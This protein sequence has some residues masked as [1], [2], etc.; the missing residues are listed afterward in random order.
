MTFYIKKT[1]ERETET[2]HPTL[3]IVFSDPTKLCLEVWTGF[4]FLS[5]PLL[6]MWIWTRTNP[7]FYLFIYLFIYLSFFSER[8]REVIRGKRE[9]Y[10]LYCFIF[11]QNVCNFC[12][13]VFFRDSAGCVFNRRHFVFSAICCLHF[14]CRHFDDRQCVIQHRVCVCVCPD[15]EWKFNHI[16][17]NPWKTG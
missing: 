2:L 8:E 16:V 13:F 7:R 14:A 3:Y 4:P 11:L 5:V 17:A 12:H 9:I 10:Y 15:R 1:Y 6:T